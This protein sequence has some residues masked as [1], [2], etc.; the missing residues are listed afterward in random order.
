M[1]FNSPGGSRNIIFQYAG[2]PILTLNASGGSAV[3]YNGLVYAD[4]G[5]GAL[6]LG[7]NGSPASNLTLS[8]S[9]A[10]LNSQF[11]LLNNTSNPYIMLGTSLNYIAYATSA[12]AFINDS[13]VGDLCI[14]S[15]SG[16]IRL[17]GGSQ[18]TTTGLLITNTGI[19]VN[20]NLNF[21]GGGTIASNSGTTYGS[22]SATG[23]KNGWYGMSMFNNRHYVMSDN[24][25]TFGLYDQTYN[26]M[27]RGVNGTCYF[28]YP[29]YVFNTVP[30]Q[31]Y[32]PNQCL[33]GN[34]STALQYGVQYSQYYANNGVS[35]FGGLYLGSFYKAS[36]SAYL[37]CS[38]SVS[39]YVSTGGPSSYFIRF[40]NTT[41]GGLY[42][43]YQY[44]YT[45]V[46]YNHVSYP[47]MVQASSLPVGTYYVYVYNGTNIVTDTNDSIYLLTEICWA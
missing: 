35:W 34:T 2:T 25:A 38:G 33:I 1:V 23:S 12:G 20:G 8:P 14:N 17:A 16:N 18:Y 29:N 4:A 46:T 31:N 27:I 45:N 42:D 47:C 28:D 15:R 19:T 21:S 41:T 6:I 37:R 40:Y 13:A 39:H 5:A 43:Y 26:W 9:N 32:L 44:N 36:A 7:V 30:Q 10:T 22:F 11:L 3:F 24:S